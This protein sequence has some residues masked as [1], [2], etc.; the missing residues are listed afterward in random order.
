MDGMPTA[1]MAVAAKMPI[2]VEGSYKMWKR[3]SVKVNMY[4]MPKFDAKDIAFY[5][6]PLWVSLSHFRIIRKMHDF[7]SADPQSA[8]YQ[9]FWFLLICFII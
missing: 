3:E 2:R 5:T 1:E 9:N 6:L 7:I 8:N 4:K